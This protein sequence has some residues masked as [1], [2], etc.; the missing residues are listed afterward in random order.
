VDGNYAHGYSQLAPGVQFWDDLGGRHLVPYA[1]FHMA[2]A[3]S[4]MDRTGEAL[5]LLDEAL[6][7]IEDTG[8]RMHEAEV[9]RVKGEVLLRADAFAIHSAETCFLK[10]LDVARSQAAKGWELRAA[11]S[12]ARL[13]RHHGRHEQAYAALSAVYEWFT[14][15]FD[16]KD[17]IEAKALLEE[18]QG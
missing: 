14:E 6:Q 12:L 9:H 16:T 4:S 3:L 11:T 7:I 5:T 1:R 2:V 13:W 15:G 17:L 8:H 18:L 10:A